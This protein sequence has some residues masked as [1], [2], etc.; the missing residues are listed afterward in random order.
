MDFVFG[1]SGGKPPH[2]MLSGGF[3]GGE[4]EGVFAAA[5]LGVEPEPDHSQAMNPAEFA[6]WVTAIKTRPPSC[7]SRV[8]HN[9]R[10]GM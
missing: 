7:R 5:F 10:G 3:G 2:S 9:S 4:E 1:E 6:A 8:K